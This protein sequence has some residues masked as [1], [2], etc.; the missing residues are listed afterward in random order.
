MAAGLTCSHDYHRPG[1]WSSGAS[2][3]H[4]R[5]PKAPT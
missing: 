4:W 2:D 5:L 3:L 1:V